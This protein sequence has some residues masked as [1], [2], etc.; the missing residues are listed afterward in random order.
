[1]AKVVNVVFKTNTKDVTKDVKGLNDEVEKTNEGVTEMSNNLDG[2]TGGAVGKIKKLGGGIKALTIGFRT[3]G[4]AIAMSGIGLVVIAIASL[5][6]ALNS[7]EEGQNKLAKWMGV[8]GAI[9]GN[10]VDL[11][12]DLGEKLIWA[13]ENPKQALIDFGTLIKENMIN[14]VEG[15]L[16]LIPAL[17][18]AISLVFKGEW[19]EAAKVAADATGKMVLGIEDITDKTSEAID[20]TKEFVEEQVKEGNAAAK[21]ADMRAKAEKLDRDLIVER[22]KKESEIAE[23]RLK[24]RKENE[25]SAEE[26]REALLEAQ[27]L[28]DELLDKETKALELK[29]EAQKLENTFSRTNKE[30]LEKEAQA[31]ADVNNQKA[32][33]ANTAR[34]LQRELN[35]IDGQVRAKQNE[36]D[37][38][39]RAKIKARADYEK[40]V[41]ESLAVDQAEKA[42]LELEKNEEKYQALID[43]AIAYGESTKELEEARDAQKKILEEKQ[44]A[45][46]EAARQK[47]LADEKKLA[48]EKAALDK[49]VGDAKIGIALNSMELIKK[50]AGEDSKIGKAMAIG[51]ATIAGI[52]S[53]I[54]AFKTAQISPITAFNPAY[55]FIQAGLAGAFAA[56]QIASMV[57]TPVG[58]AGGGGGGGSTPSVPSLGASSSIAVSTGNDTGSQVADAINNKPARAYV[59]SGDVTTQ[60]SLD[61]RIKTNATFG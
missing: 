5:G 32:K 13:F 12:A 23:L 11:L 26:R 38:E 16:E 4:G 2:M 46:I 34:Q 41:R 36:A 54:E 22:S 19:S 14:R 6:A 59:V 7:S 10:F 58:G 3:L 50:I 35:T 44:A 18:K 53:T 47:D 40:E 9:T 45:R 56:T 33:R 37:A 48:D 1:M 27:K 49:A 55:P 25:F 57:A 29:F 60:Q 43:Q 39:E 20:K 21:V 15:M 31:E 28:E 8:I 17:G 52:Q 24:A 42:A 61:R 51:Q 30:N